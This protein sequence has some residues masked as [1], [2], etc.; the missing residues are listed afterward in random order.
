MVLLQL[1]DLGAIREETEFLSCV[2]CLFRRYV[3]YSKLMKATLNSRNFLLL[4]VYLLCTNFPLVC[5][6]VCITCFYAR[7]HLSSLYWTACLFCFYVISLCPLTICGMCP[8]CRVMWKL[9]LTVRCLSTV[10]QCV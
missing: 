6:I 3:S 2:G 8:N 9:S 4:V 1:R 7:L 5:S 10:P